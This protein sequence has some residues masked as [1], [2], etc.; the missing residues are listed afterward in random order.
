MIL[1][2]IFPKQMHHVRFVLLLN[3]TIIGA[4]L[5]TQSQRRAIA[6]KHC[7]LFEHVQTIPYRTQCAYG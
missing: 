1:K 6:G 7:L 5:I 3:N 4:N 2:K